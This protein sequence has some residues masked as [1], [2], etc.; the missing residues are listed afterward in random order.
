LIT[1]D[2]KKIASLDR[3]YSSPQIVAQRVQL[4]AAI[5]ARP[6]ERGLDVGCGAGHMLCELAAEVGPTGHITG[7][8]ASDDAVAAC[9]ARVARDGF[10]HIVDI[11]RCDAAALDFPDASFDFVTGAQSYCYVPDVA[12]AMCEAARVLRPGGRLH[13]LDTDWDVCAWKS[14]DDARMRRMFDERGAAQFAHPHLPRQLHAHLA[15][16]GLRLDAVSAVPIIETR[17]DPDSWVAGLIDSV[18][19]GAK[20]AGVPPDEIKAWEEDLRS[21]TGDGDPGN[22]FFCLNR[23]I[24]SATKP[25]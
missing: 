2:A 14:A 21:R 17:F 13:V 4:R 18:R 15:A 20:K 7:I 6:G 8:D 5:G 25:C 9:T 3:V 24:F 19:G 1:F 12:G 16:A 10:A 11:R 23:L 22:W